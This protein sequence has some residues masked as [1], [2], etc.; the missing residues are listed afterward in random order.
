V[1]EGGR[2]RE[3]MYVCMYVCM[4]V[5]VCVC[6]CIYV[7][8]YVCILSVCMYISP[9]RWSLSG[10]LFGPLSGRGNAHRHRSPGPEREAA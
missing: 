1:R 9:H 7:C 5:C 6:V 3:R 2:E 4:C 10:T 8:M